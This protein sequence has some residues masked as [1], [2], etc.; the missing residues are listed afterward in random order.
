MQHELSC[1]ATFL[2]YA[3]ILREA[4]Q[5]EK[6]VEKL[7]S[8]LMLPATV[9]NALVV[10]EAKGTTH[11][12]DL[13]E[14]MNTFPFPQRESGKKMVEYWIARKKEKFAQYKWS[15]E[16]TVR[17]TSSGQLIVRVEARELTS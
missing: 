13:L 11:T 8:L 10:D 1:S 14:R 12:K 2:E 7:K 9:W 17:K 6:S 3:T 15:V 4:T 16:P 5:N